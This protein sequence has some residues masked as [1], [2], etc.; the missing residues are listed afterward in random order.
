MREQESP[1][2]LFWHTALKLEIL[3][4]SFVRSLHEADFG[5]YVDSITKLVPWCFI[6]DHTN[7]AHWLPV[8]INT[9]TASTYNT[10]WS[11]VPKTLFAG[12]D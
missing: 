6:L 8:H 1:Q 11:S 3:V 2:F 12:F 9:F 7:D 10:L 4:L 5:L